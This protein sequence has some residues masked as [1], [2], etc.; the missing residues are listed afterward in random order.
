VSLIK[1]IARFI[2]KH[3]DAWAGEAFTLVG[4]II[5]WILVEP[6]DTRNTIAVICIGAFAI[7]TLFKVTFNSEK[8]DS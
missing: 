7:W 3:L 6:G 8:E 4:L 1:A 5:A 2:W